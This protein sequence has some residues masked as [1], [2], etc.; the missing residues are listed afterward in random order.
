MRPGK[1]LRG[2]QKTAKLIARPPGA[3]D[4]VDHSMKM[5]SKKPPEGGFTL[6]PS[7]LSPSLKQ[8]RRLEDASP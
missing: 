2:L 1:K 4:A 7:S 8:Q 5:K 3:E 6:S